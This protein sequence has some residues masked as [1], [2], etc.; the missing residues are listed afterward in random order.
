MII[1]L[2]L[3]FVA[4]IPSEQIGLKMAIK[5]CGCKHHDQDDMYGVGKRV[6][7][8]TAKGYRCTVCDKEYLSGDSK[9]K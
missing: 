5:S 3:L 2:F 1:I 4:F 7:N 6:M 8:P 9:K